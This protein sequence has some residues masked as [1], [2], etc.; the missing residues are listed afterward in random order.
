MDAFTCAKTIKA[1]ADAKNATAEYSEVLKEKPSAEVGAP[2]PIIVMAFLVGLANDEIGKLN[3]QVISEACATFGK[4][5][6]PEDIYDT[7]QHFQVKDCYEQSQVKIVIVVTDTNLRK[8]IVSGLKQ[9]G[10]M[11]RRNKAPRSALEDEMQKFLASLQ[12][13]KDQDS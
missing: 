9:L 3:K 13:K 7:V 5:D 1:I 11:H 6:E 10:A 4:L 2:M 12:L 8:A